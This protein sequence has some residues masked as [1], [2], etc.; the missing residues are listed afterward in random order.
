MAA[1]CPGSSYCRSPARATLGSGTCWRAPRASSPP[2]SSPTRSSSGQ[3][4]HRGREHLCLIASAC[5][6]RNGVGYGRSACL[7]ISLCFSLCR[8]RVSGRGRRPGQR[9][10]T[11]AEEPR[12][13]RQVAAGPRGSPRGGRTK[14]AGRSAAAG[15]SQVKGRRMGRPWI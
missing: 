13:R 6:Q 7:L 4:R 14:H 1:P 9:E 10:D 5:R 3:V 15:P 11:G 12:L 8:S 2:P